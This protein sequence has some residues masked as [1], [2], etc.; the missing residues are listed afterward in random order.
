MVASPIPIPA[1]PV[2]PAGGVNGGE[3]FAPILREGYAG[4]RIANVEIGRAG[5]R[6]GVKVRSFDRKDRW[7]AWRKRSKKVQAKIALR[8]A[9][10][11]RKTKGKKS[12]KKVV[13][14]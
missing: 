3:L 6:A 13:L 10:R 5:E 2:V 7:L 1:Q 8:A 12:N 11:T 9:G 14:P 4:N